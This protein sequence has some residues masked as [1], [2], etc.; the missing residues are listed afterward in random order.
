VSDTSNGLKE[1]HAELQAAL[2]PLG[3]ELGGEVLLV[4][5]DRSRHSQQ[6]PLPRTALRALAEWAAKQLAE[7]S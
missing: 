3:I 1:A 5:V 4:W 7:S 6:E 2:A